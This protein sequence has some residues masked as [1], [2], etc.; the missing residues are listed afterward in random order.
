MALGERGLAFLLATY[1]I[2]LSIAESIRDT[3]FDVICTARPEIRWANRALPCV[4]SENCSGEEE[5]VTRDV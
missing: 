2:P 5:G 1:S 3:V 4:D